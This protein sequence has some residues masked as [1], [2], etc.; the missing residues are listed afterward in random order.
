MV[1]LIMGILFAIAMASWNSV[2][3]S[4]RVDS[5]ANQLASDMRLAH[6]SAVNQLTDWRVVYKVG[7][8]KY[9]LIKLSAVCPLATCSNP[10]AEE[11]IARELPQGTEIVCS[12]NNA[13]PSAN[14]RFSVY[15]ALGNLLP[16]TINNP[17]TTSTIEFN[18]DGSSYASSGPNAGLRVGSNNANAWKI[19]VESTTSRV[20]VKNKTEACL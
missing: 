4:R 8:S 2:I 1:I 20:K 14:L 12:S 11:V 7:D 5:A 13:D 9:H 15:D 3:E 19:T 6:S 16:A 10:I 18:S 17:G